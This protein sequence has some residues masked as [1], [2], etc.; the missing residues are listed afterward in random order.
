MGSEMCIRD[1][2]HIMAVLSKLD[3]NA[4][5][6]TVQDG[7]PASLSWIGAA[8]RRKVYSLGLTEFGQSGNL[9]D[10]YHTYGIDADA[11]IQMAAKA[12]IDLASSL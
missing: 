12:S 4:A 5:I 10:L 9:P 11:I 3:E 2:P 1:S 8:S 6:I 7:H